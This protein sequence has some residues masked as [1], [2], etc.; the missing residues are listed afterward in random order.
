MKYIT[1]ISILFFGLNSCDSEN[2][3]AKELCDCYTQLHRASSESEVNFWGD[4]C[5]TLYIDIIKA[6]DNNPSKKEAFNKA[7]RRC[8]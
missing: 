2:E 1:I 8:Q 6:L 5:N 4:S 3:Y 7:Y